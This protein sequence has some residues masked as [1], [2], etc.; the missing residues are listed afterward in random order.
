MRIELGVVE[1]VVALG[2]AGSRM[3]RPTAIVGWREHQ[4]HNR[5][6][7]EEGRDREGNRQGAALDRDAEVEIYWDWRG[8]RQERLPGRGIDSSSGP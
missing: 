8:L 2:E 5:H 6:R 3:R 7:A 1:A 4:L